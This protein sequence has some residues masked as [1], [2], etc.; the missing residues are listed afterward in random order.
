ME[1]EVGRNNQ[2]ALR[3]MFTKSMVQCA[4]LIAPYYYQGKQ[5]VIE[6]GRNFYCAGCLQTKA[7]CDA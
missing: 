1:T 3:R 2:R 4:T 5:V 6:V 7:Y